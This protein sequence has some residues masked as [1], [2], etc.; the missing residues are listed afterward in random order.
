MKLQFYR[1]Y[2]YPKINTLE[3]LLYIHQFI[4]CIRLKTENNTLGN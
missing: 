3:F 4:F 1:I 2:T